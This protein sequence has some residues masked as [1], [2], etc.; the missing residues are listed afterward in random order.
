MSKYNS[1]LNSYSLEAEDAGLSVPVMSP[2]NMLSEDVSGV[3]D[4][5]KALMEQWRALNATSNNPIL[6]V[7]LAL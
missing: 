1:F 2:T 3:S 7:Q 4:M 6:Q 5:V